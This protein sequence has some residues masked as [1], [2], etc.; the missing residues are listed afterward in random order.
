MMGAERTAKLARLP[1]LDSHQVGVFS[2]VLVLGELGT[3]VVHVHALLCDK[4]TSR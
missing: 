4:H 2:A 3:G 1:A